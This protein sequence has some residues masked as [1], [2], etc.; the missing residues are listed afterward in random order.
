MSVTRAVGLQTAAVLLEIRPPP[1]LGR[2]TV[3]RN[4]GGRSRDG[5]VDK[6]RNEVR[7]HIADEQVV[8]HETILE[9]SVGKP[10]KLIEDQRWNGGQR[11]FL[12]VGR[13]D[14][15]RVESWHF[16]ASPSASRDGSAPPTRLGG[17]RPRRALRHHPPSG[18]RSQF[19][20]AGQ[21]RRRCGR[22][23]PSRLRRLDW[24]TTV[25]SCTGSIAALLGHRLPTHKN[26]VGGRRRSAA[27]RRAAGCKPENARS[28]KARHP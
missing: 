19:S 4:P 18:D 20:S 10:R 2:T 16:L 21:R 27:L 24:L 25:G 6:V 1:E 9:L 3:H 15:R 5:I 14:A 13:I 12:G 22:E 17:P 26:C 7:H 11:Q 23:T 28:L 8:P